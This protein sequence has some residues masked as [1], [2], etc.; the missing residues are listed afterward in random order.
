MGSIQRGIWISSIVLTLFA[1]VGIILGI[2]VLL[3][4]SGVFG[5]GLGQPLLITAGIIGI[6]TSI[7]QLVV[8]CYGIRGTIDARHTHTLLTLAIIALI[9]AG[10]GLAFYSVDMGMTMVNLV[11]NVIG[12]IISVIAAAVLMFCSGRVKSGMRPGDA[13]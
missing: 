13:F 4:G 12:S 5:V 1:L 7:Y 8:G 3:F 11:P 2:V 6:A 10:V 9:C